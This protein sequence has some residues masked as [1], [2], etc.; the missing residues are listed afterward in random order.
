MSLIH[1]PPCAV[2]LKVTRIS[3]YDKPACLSAPPKP[4]AP[5]PPEAP[6]WKEY[7]TPEGKVYYSDGKTSLWDE[8]DELK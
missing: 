6:K 3:T 1:T 8:P 4:V 5:T 2:L 7:K